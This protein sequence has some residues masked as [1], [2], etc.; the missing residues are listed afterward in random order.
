MV[1]SL[2]QKLQTANRSKLQTNADDDD[3]DSAGWVDGE[4]DP[5][6]MCRK[7]YEKDDFWI[8]C[9]K[10]KVCV[11]YVSVSCINCE[12][13]R[14]ALPLSLSACGAGK[15]EQC[16]WQVISVWLEHCS[17]QASSMGGVGIL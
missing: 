12:S 8:E 14:C 15:C 4:G 1:I 9:D 17:K 7:F 11:T 5:C 3:E 6:P 10:C 13:A 16:V 2:N